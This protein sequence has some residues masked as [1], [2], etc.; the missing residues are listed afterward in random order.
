MFVIKSWKGERFELNDSANGH[1]DKTAAISEG[2]FK[3]VFGKLKAVFQMGHLYPD[4]I[5]FSGQVYVPIAEEPIGVKMPARIAEMEAEIEEYETEEY[6]DEPEYCRICG[7]LLENCQVPVL[8]TYDDTMCKH[9][10][11]RTY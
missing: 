9:M 5:L 11:M 4:A 7:D 10:K 3:S 6:E 1:A 2:R 8:G